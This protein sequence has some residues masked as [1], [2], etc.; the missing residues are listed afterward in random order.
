M[1]RQFVGTRAGAIGLLALLAGLLSG[2]SDLKT[3]ESKEPP[4]LHI[5]A[6]KLK[7]GNLDIISSF[8]AQIHVGSID[9]HCQTSY[10]GTV[11]LSDKPVDIGVPVGRQNYLVVEFTNNSHWAAYNATSATYKTLFTPRAGYRYDMEVAYQDGGYDIAIYEHG[12]QGGA[13]HE[14]DHRPF[15]ACG[16]S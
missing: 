16:K 7:S 8:S 2:C 5:V 11:E 3:Y 4:N 6:K 9:S 1:S 12:R 15:S 14:V 13:R 10:V